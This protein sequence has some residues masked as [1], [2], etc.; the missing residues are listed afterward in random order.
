MEIG[1]VAETTHALPIRTNHVLAV[2]S[3]GAAPLLGGVW[4]HQVSL[5]QSE[6]QSR[7]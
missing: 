2:I 6:P 1:S 5:D 4:E 3:G 7:D